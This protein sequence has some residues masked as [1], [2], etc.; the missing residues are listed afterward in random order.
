[1]NDEQLYDR[2][3]EQSVLGVCMMSRPAR[4]EARRH[5]SGKDFYEPRHEVLWD[6]MAR[7]DKHGKAVDP[8]TVLA[9]V[10]HDRD[11]VE[12]LPNMVT[13]M[14]IP[15]NVG[16]YASIVRSWAMRRRLAEEGR[17][18][19]QHAMNPD[20]NVQGFAAQVATRFASLRD[21]G[22]TEDA[23]S[24]TLEELLL[25][26]DDEPDWLIPGLLERRDRMILTGEEGL[27]KSY[28]LRQIAVMAAAGLDPFDPGKRI[29]PL[30]VTIFDC[31]N[32]TRQVKRK[33]RPVVEFAKHWGTGNPGQVNLLCSPRVDITR[34]KDLARI[35]FE[36]D[37]TQ[38]DI[39]VIGP[40]Y[41]LTQGA[42][43]TDDDAA[44][45]LAALDTIRDR[46]ISLLIEAHAGHAIGA[47][48]TRNLRPRG[49]S[50][51]LGWPEF[52]YGMKTV[53]SG[54]A[55]LVPWRGDRDERHWPAR[56]K[57]DRARIRWEPVEVR[58]DEEWTPT[59]AIA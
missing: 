45:V 29:K 10:N 53:A 48:G 24:I 9:V 26:P 50:A 1:V 35:H 15:E 16:E 23:Q 27:G 2:V 11:I 37:A 33:V 57:Q 44:P 14:G 40:L 28:L 52:G 49:S 12:L 39:L 36:L 13:T 6:V 56:V 59:G 41:R 3:A 25:E 42:L 54:F 5:L 47:G 4:D 58:E 19:V 7:L 46:D 31:E 32:S 51:L 17:R 21:S 18:V 30:S 55:D 8:M 38:P 43:Q 34:D 22:I 20:A